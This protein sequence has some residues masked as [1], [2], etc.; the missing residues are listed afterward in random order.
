MA[1]VIGAL[2]AVGCTVAG[3]GPTPNIPETVEA[4]IAAAFPTETPNIDATV[5]A[6]IRATLE[7]QSASAESVTSDAVPTITPP[8]SL[9]ETIQRVRP[10][11]VRIESFEGSGSGVIIETSGQTGIVLTNFHVIED[12]GPI[13]VTVNDSRRYLA[14]IRGTDPIRDLAVLN[15]CCGTFL[16]IDIAGPSVVEPGSEVFSMGYPINLAGSATVT[17][18][19]VSATRYDAARLSEVIQSDAAINPGNSGGPMLLPSGEIIGIN[20]FKYETSPSGRPVEGLGFAISAKTIKE[21]LT[22]LKSGSYRVL[23]TPTPRP[24]STPRPTIV[25]TPA[26]TSTPVIFDDFGNSRFSAASVNLSL[27]NSPIK[28]TGSIETGGDVDTF[29]FQGNPG[30]T[31]AF[32]ANYLL[33]GSIV[34]AIGHPKLVLYTTFP[35]MPLAIDDRGG[36]LIYV[37]SGGTIYLDVSAY[38]ARLTSDYAIVIDRIN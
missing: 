30:E 3:P 25:P 31:F 35:S 5:E 37:T 26:P 22:A 36:N 33:R 6:G 12:G 2:V 29:V 14:T 4:A 1:L 11:I 28:I 15:I 9:A 23:P 8:P 7:A 38:S 24:T 27:A 13:Y 16:P 17:R 18:G 21:Q 19:I 10:A 32:S 20:T 34:T